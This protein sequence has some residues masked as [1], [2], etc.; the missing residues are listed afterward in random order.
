LYFQPAHDPTAATDAPIISVFGQERAMEP[1]VEVSMGGRQYRLRG[2][3]AASLQRLAAE[4]DSALADV[5][6]HAAPVEDVKIAV[7]A[8]LNI[9]SEKDTVRRALRQRLEAALVRIAQM[10]QRV[11]R[12]EGLAAPASDH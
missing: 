5:A 12:L 3:D 11:Q 7:L 2:G 10:E 6:P 4:V 9:A 1:T 8:A